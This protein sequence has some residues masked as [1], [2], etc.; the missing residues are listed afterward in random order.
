MKYAKYMSRR[1]YHTVLRVR[2]NAREGFICATFRWRAER[3]LIWH[4]AWPWTEKPSTALYRLPPKQGAKSQRFALLSVLYFTPI[5][6][7]FHRLQQKSLSSTWNLCWGELERD[8]LRFTVGQ[9]GR[10]ILDFTLHPLTLKS[11]LK[12]ARFTA[13]LKLNRVLPF[14]IY[15]FSQYLGLVGTTFSLA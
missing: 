14:F 2:T 3:T 15:A 6:P 5:S 9:Q 4:T 12:R 11:F 10:L 7:C 8:Y 1:L 13:P